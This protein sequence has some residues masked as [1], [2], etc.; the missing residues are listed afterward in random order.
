MRVKKANFDSINLSGYN[1]LSV[2]LHNENY[3]VETVKGKN[4]WQPHKWVNVFNK[5]LTQ[6]ITEASIISDVGSWLKL[7]LKTYSRSQ[8]IQ[9]IEYAG[10]HG[11]NNRS[12]LVHYHLKEMFS[13]LQYTVIS[14]I[15]VAIDYTKIPRKLIKALEKDRKP[16]EYLNSTYFK[17]PKE[18][19]KNLYMNV[20]WYDKAKKENLNEPMERIEFSFGASFFKG[21]QLKDL[22]EAIEKMEKAINRKLGI[23]VKINPL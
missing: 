23:V 6:N 12:E 20:V 19:K 11:Y 18:G 21:L 9:V 7:P 5:K 15:D 3:T 14:R 17:T 8:T 4:V 1:L 13:Y 22:S 2:F 16:F 10:I